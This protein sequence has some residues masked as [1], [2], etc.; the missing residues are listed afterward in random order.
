MGHVPT[1]PAS[2]YRTKAATIKSKAPY[3]FI[4]DEDGISTGD[5]IKTAATVAVVSSLMDDDSPSFGGGSFS[6]GG[7]SGSWDD[8]D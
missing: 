7:S 6:G 8:D 3:R 5:I 4:H 2:A 1:K